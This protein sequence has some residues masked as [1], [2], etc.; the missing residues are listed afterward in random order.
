MNINYYKYIKIYNN[1]QNYIY[2]FIIQLIHILIHNNKYKQ[3]M[4]Q[5]FINKVIYLKI[6]MKMII[7]M[8]I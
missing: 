2:H 7:I 5:R 8:L 4:N 3:L 1:Y 6:L